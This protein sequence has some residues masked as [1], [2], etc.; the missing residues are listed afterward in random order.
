M[1]LSGDDGGTCTLPRDALPLSGR[2]PLTYETLKQLRIDLKVPQ[3]HTL[4][5]QDVNGTGLAAATESNVEAYTFQIDWKDVEIVT[6]TH[7]VAPSSSSTRDLKS[8][9]IAEVGKF[10]VAI[11]SP[12]VNDEAE[13]GDMAAVILAKEKIKGNSLLKYSEEDF[14]DIGIKGPR[15]RHLHAMVEKARVNGVG[16]DFL[17]L[18]WDEADP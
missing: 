13:Y 7:E 2:G 16:P 4:S 1:Q 11:F 9:D 10:A 17:P 6:L 15:K 5:V 14:H 12:P 8:L 3:S 18:R